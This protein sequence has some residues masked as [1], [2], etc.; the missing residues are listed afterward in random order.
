[1]SLLSDRY[2]DLHVSDG[3]SIN[4][5]G[6]PW[7]RRPG[8]SSLA[9]PRSA[10]KFDYRALVRDMARLTRFLTGH[11]PIGEFRERFHLDGCVG[12]L[13]GQ[14]VEDRH[15]ILFECPLWIR[16]WED[17]GRDRDY[18][19]NLDPF[20]IVA[21][22]LNI[23]FHAATFEFADLREKAAMQINAGVV[24]GVFVEQ[25]FHDT[26]KRQKIWRDARALH[27]STAAADET[28]REYD[29]Q[30]DADKILWP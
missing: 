1:M 11:A 6:L 24:D 26:L 9:D 27:N 13:C 30:D 10:H 8:T 2:D 15:H 12:C 5:H 7:N 23:N 17:H 25:L 18:L 22:F 29:V 21:W 28:L 20:A 4:G 14:P 16:W 19:K 3:T